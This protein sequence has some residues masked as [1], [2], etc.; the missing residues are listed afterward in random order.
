MSRQPKLDD[1][2]GVLEI[3]EKTGQI[4]QTAARLG[5][6]AATVSRFL[7]RHGFV[8]VPCSYEKWRAYNRNQRARA[9]GAEGWH[10]ADDVARLYKDQHGRCI[11]CGIRIFMRVMF[12]YY[13]DHVVSIVRG[14]TNW[15]SNLA[16]C[17]LRC[18]S[19][20]CAMPVEE[21]RL[22]QGR[23]RKSSR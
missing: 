15:P 23:D 9:L 12:G 20:K 4:K 21:F 13:V 2:E 11:Y 14:G 16:L 18:N 1:P 17:C 10:T 6:C 8:F 22:R 3:L 5:V 7:R 19:R